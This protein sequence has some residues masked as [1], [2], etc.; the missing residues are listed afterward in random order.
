M[1]KYSSWAS[2][3]DHLK[4][5]TQLG[6]LGKR[7]AKGQKPA[8]KKTGGKGPFKLYD[9]N[10]AVDK[11]TPSPAQLAALDKARI[12][13][14]AA[15]RCAHCGINFGRRG[16][17]R[18][19][20]NHVDG[21]ICAD[22]VARHE[23]RID[24]RRLLAEGFVV[25][26][27]ETTGLDEQAEIVSIGIIDHTGQVLLDRL[28]RPTQPIPAEVIDIH[29]ITNEAVAD[30]PTMADI[31]D[32]VRYLL[33]GQTVVIYN[34]AFDVRLLDQSLRAHQIKNLLQ[35]ENTYCAMEAAKTYLNRER[36]LSLVNAADYFD[37][38]TTG[39]HGAIADCRM[40]LGVIK[41]MADADH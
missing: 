34:A 25:L 19:R 10:E 7:L 32:E 36:W 6:K 33:E 35:I 8:A 23:E 22:C 9:I 20:Y 38:P 14:E 31:Y 1:N 11:R 2:V 24:A 29:G 41:G 26:D 4:T 15:N 28:V 39:A 16:R 18:H 40:T 3:P 5:K 27:T 12:A 21:Y 17:Y 13:A 30:A 37:L